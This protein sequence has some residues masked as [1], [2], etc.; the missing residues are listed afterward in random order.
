MNLEEISKLKPGDIIKLK[1]RT[2][3]WHKQ[4]GIN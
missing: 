4:M 3:L 2:S 1:K